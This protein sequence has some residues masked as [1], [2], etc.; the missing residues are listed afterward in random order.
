M[1]KWTKE[2]VKEL[3]NLTEK[4]LSDIKIAED[5]L[6]KFN[7]RFTAMSVK[8]KRHKLN[9]F[10]KGNAIINNS[11][12]YIKV[13]NKKK[14]LGFCPAYMPL[15]IVKKNNIKNGNILILQKNN[16]F[17]FSKIAKIIR[18]DR[19]N[20]YYNFY[21]PYKLIGSTRFNT[22]V[23][24]YIGKLDDFEKNYPLISKNSIEL[25]TLLDN[26]INEKIQICLH[27][28]DNNKIL[29]NNGR[30]SVPIELP[31]KIELSEQL[32]QCLGFFQGE[33]SKGHYRRVEITNTDSNLLNLFITFFRNALGIKKVQW[34][35]RVGYTKQNK[36]EILEKSLIEYW[37][38]KVSIPA[39]NFVKSYWLQGNPDAPKGGVQL[40]LPSSSLREVWFNLLRL[41][42][43][44]VLED[45][46]YA[47]WFLQGVLAADGCPIFSNGKLRNVMIRIENG[48]EGQ[49]YH[50]A[51]KRLGIYST[52][53]IKQRAITI[54][55]FSEIVKVQ[56]FDLFKLHEERREKFI[57][58][59][60]TRNF[61]IKIIGG[62]QM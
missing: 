56:L 13:S 45:K 25:L 12:F 34:R 59:L 28:F 20:D 22:E 7:V 57:S 32:F 58:G 37:G 50:S 62:K 27:P 21:V 51:L 41:S 54:H 3:E 23:I 38:E 33:G 5:L 17:F 18:N 43:K 26:K 46:N 36:D 11:A 15:K 35:A 4:G 8:R 47:K 14:G 31:R 48:D 52:L 39:K 42:H 2:Y 60:K 61:Q 19:P 44:L 29:I 53:S 30:A 16:Q 10:K 24:K 1:I 9:L 49:L 6:N 40:Y 55:R